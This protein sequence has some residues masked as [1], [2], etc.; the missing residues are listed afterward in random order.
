MLGYYETVQIDLVKVPAKVRL[1]A[2]K[3]APGIESATSVSDDISF[4]LSAEEARALGKNL[5][6]NADLVE[7]M[8]RE[9][10]EYFS[11]QRAIDALEAQAKKTAYFNGNSAEDTESYLCD[12]TKELLKELRE[13]KREMGK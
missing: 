11:V 6:G 1:P 7:Q 2:S 8:D 10:K 12:E 4:A 3:I 5:I 9:T 13:Y